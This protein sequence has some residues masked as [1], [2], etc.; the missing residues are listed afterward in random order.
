METINR[1]L[2]FVAS[3][4]DSR[5]IRQL[6]H[7]LA[8]VVAVVV[9]LR[10]ASTLRR[11]GLKGLLRAAAASVLDAARSLPG[12]EAAIEAG[13]DAALAE[14]IEDVAPKTSDPTSELPAEGRGAD[15]IL[16]PLAAAMQADLSAS[17]FN[18]GA[19]FGGIYHTVAPPGGASSPSSSSTSAPSQPSPASLTFLQSSVASVFLN[20]NQLYPTLFRSA[21]RAEAEAVSIAVNL[22]KGRGVGESSSAAASASSSS[23]TDPAPDACGVFTSGGTESVL[24]AVK[25]YRDAALERLGYVDSTDERGALTPAVASAARDGIVLDVIAGISAHPALDK[26]CA[27]FGLRLVKLDVDGATRA[28]APSAV[29]AALS[30]TTAFVYTSAPGFAHGVVDPIS[31]IGQVCAGYTSSPWGRDGV[32]V[33]VDNCLGGVH[34]SF[35]YALQEEEKG[36]GKGAAGTKPGIPCFDFRAHPSVRTISMDLHKYGGVPKGASIVAFREPSLR[37][38][39][40]SV[41]TVFP[42]GYYATPTLAGSRSGAPG[43]L[44][45]STLLHMGANGYREEAKVV[46]GLHAQISA[47][48]ASTPGLVLVGTPHACIV[49][50]TSSPASGFSPYAVA[51]RMEERGWHVP[52]LQ[53]PAAMHVCISERMAGPAGGADGSAGAGKKGERVVDA[54]LRDLAASAAEALA[55]PSDPKYE[56]KGTA[57]IYGAAS[58]LPGAEVGRILKRYCDILYLVR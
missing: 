1:I 37:R 49:A 57:A 8:V 52:L 24:V 44:A 54:W 9:A 15:G 50:F 56:G 45:W 16:A 14:L 31:E 39:A 41:V 25:A 4:P 23:S 26:G 47:A 46:A 10:T 27:T 32:P 20:T 58:V 48:I 38:H 3:A 11:Q 12:G 34:L 22:L 13:L 2:S 7:V 17:G 40:Y 6:E 36:K 51:A 55:N 5:S 21:R 28:L 33:H 18:R 19:A 29:A 42:G 43:A 35:A 53:T 30:P